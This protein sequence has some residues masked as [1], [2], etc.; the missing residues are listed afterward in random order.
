MRHVRADQ[1]VLNSPFEAPAN[2]TKCLI[3]CAASPVLCDHSLPDRLQ[4]QGTE[5]IGDRPAVQFANEFQ[6]IL[7]AA[8][9]TSNLVAFAVV[10]LSESTVSF[11]NFDNGLLNTA[12]KLSSVCEELGDQ[13]IVFGFTCPSIP[14]PR[15]DVL[16]VDS[17]RS[18]PGGLVTTA[19]R[20]AKRLVFQHDSGT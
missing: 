15:T 11:E 10:I 17:D 2:P 12:L 8:L 18:M 16:T 19:G 9:F 3:D 14:C 4:C 5:I 13:P 7:D 1:F 6:G 20:D